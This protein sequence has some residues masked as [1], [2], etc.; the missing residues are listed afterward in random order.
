MQPTQE[1]ASESSGSAQVEAETHT[2]RDGV[3][4]REIERKKYRRQC[5]KVWTVSKYCWMKNE[6][7]NLRKERKGCAGLD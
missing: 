4:V 5:Q 6:R 2:F 3:Y 1:K 7:R